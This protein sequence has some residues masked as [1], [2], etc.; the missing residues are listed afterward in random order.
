MEPRAGAGAPQFAHA[1]SMCAFALL[2][3]LNLAAPVCAPQAS[4][5]GSVTRAP[6]GHASST[7]ADG[8]L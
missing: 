5:S 2:G 7:A 4:I 1:W 8:Q 6:P 3:A